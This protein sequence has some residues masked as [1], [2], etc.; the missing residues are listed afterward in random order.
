M[1]P[2][3]STDTSHY[4]SL[5]CIGEHAPTYW[6]N[7]NDSW[8]GDVVLMSAGELA[9]F[10][11]AFPNNN[12]SILAL[13]DDDTACEIKTDRDLAAAFIN[14]ISVFSRD[15]KA[16]KDSLGFSGKT[17]TAAKSGWD[18]ITAIASLIKTNDDLIGVAVANTVTGYATPNANWAWIGDNQARYGWVNLVIK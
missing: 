7:D 5:Y 4:R 13:E 16:A 18:L 17:L 6:N 10:H 8:S 3:T 12:Y 1:G 14:A 2:A 15:F 9:A 11:T